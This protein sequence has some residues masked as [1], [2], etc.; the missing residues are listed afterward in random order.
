MPQQE[1]EARVRV[2]SRQTL[3]V[4]AAAGNA[5]ALPSQ[6][7][8]LCSE[9]KPA[10]DMEPEPLIGPGDKSEEVQVGTTSRYSRKASFVQETS[11]Q[12][13]IVRIDKQIDVPARSRQ[14]ALGSPQKD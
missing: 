13:G 5:S 2:W 4:D 7:K 10:C 14:S 9:G 6:W 8:W 11:S 12:I 3:L 1:P